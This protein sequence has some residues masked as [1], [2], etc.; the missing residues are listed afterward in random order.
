[1]GGQDYS[2]VFC[3]LFDFKGRAVRMG[4]CIIA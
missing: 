1:M 3:F 4:S 2:E